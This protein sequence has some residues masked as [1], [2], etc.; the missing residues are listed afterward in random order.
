MTMDF[1]FRLSRPFSVIPTTLGIEDVL[2]FTSVSFRH[3]DVDNVVYGTCQKA[4]KASSTLG[5]IAVTDVRFHVS[6]DVLCSVDVVM[7]MFMCRFNWLD[8]S[9]IT[10]VVLSCC[11]WH[12]WP[13]AALMYSAAQ[14]D[15]GREG[16]CQRAWGGDLQ[17]LNALSLKPGTTSGSAGFS[18][19][20]WVAASITASLAA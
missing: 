7:G 5:G 12:D 13:I 8:C 1:S 19:P 18:F 4:L 3:V 16:I 2:L 11:P 20:L 10:I 17:M 6:C 15:G 9:P 14:Y